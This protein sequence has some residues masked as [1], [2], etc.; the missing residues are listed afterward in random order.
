MIKYIP[1]SNPEWIAM[2]N[3]HVRCKNYT[4]HDGVI[5]KLAKKTTN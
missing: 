4:K 2:Y 3:E 1:L 5:D